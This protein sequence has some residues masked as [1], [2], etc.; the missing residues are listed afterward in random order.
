M[1]EDGLLLIRLDPVQQIHRLRLV[2]VEPGNL[3]RQQGD[4]K[5]LKA[6]IAVEQSE[7]LEHD[8]RAGKALRS[9]VLVEFLAQILIDLVAGDQFAL[10]AMQD[11]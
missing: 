9:F 4:H 8:L 5:R 1:R 10:Y 11:R 7:L 6:E 2:V 3:L